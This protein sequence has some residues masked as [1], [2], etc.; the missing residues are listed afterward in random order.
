MRNVVLR[1][2]R[3]RRTVATVSLEELEGVDLPDATSHEPI[4]RLVD[5]EDRIELRRSLSVYL[6]FYFM[7]YL[8]LTELQRVVLHQVEISGRNYRQI[9]SELG[10]RVEAVKMVVY[11]AR[12]RLNANMQR[13]AAG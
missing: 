4:R 13:A 2:L 5:D 11:R 8:G 12:K 1:C 6:Q 10:M 7:A 9:A 3:R